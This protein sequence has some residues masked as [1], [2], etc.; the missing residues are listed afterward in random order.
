MKIILIIILTITQAFAIDV[1]PIK[2]GQP[3]PYDGFI[4]DK[5]NIKE[6]RKIN[7]EKKLLEKEN[8]KLKDLSII[9]EERIENYKS[10][11]DDADKEL[12]WEKT[13]GNMKGIGGFILG[14]V[15]TSLAA[16]AAIKI[17]K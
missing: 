9:N 2:K 3:A 11:A 6:M 16:Y 7:E 17:S 15:A 10:F 4:I 13:K 1:D 14:V 12:R 8:I 5:D